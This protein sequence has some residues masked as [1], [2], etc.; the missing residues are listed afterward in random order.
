M[1]DQFVGNDGFRPLPLPATGEELLEGRQYA[2]TPLARLILREEY[3]LSGVATIVE[4]ISRKVAHTTIT[5]TTFNHETKETT[6]RV[7]EVEP[8][9]ATFR[10]Q[11][12]KLR[13]QL[14]IKKLDEFAPFYDKSH[15]L[16]AMEAEWFEQRHL[17]PVHHKFRG[18]SLRWW[19]KEQSG[20][21]ERISTGA[22][23]RERAVAHISLA[24]LD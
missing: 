3:G 4:C 13:F 1:S 15:K 7:M 5:S 2:L 6:V 11:G 17:S 10:V 16:P 22:K 20:T 23:K 9:P 12:T 14:D 18:C 8:Q 24:D 19:S 21:A